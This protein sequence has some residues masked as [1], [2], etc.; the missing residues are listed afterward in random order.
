MMSTRSAP[1]LFLGLLLVLPALGSCSGESRAGD[2]LVFTA[3]PDDNATALSARFQPLAD[4][5]SA[6]LGVAVRYVPTS[7]YEASVEAFK[8]GDVQLAW[9]GGLTGAQARLAVP[10]SRAVA[11][12]K[13]DPHFKSYFIAHVDTGIEPS[14]AFPLELAQRS[15]TFG[16]SSSTSGRLMPEYYLRKYTGKS[17]TEFFGSAENFSGSHDKTAALVQ[18]GTFEAGALN[19][20]T[21]DRLVEDG[22]IDPDVARVVWTTPEYADYNWTAHP[23]LEER[24]GADFIDKLQGALVGLKDPELLK[25]VD[26]VEGLIPASNA[27]FEAIAELARELGFV[28]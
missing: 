25:A 12:G 15:F 9:F 10:G 23:V 13:V 28:R 24:F 14:D 1:H 6:E 18:A 22:T 7:S 11:Q 4:R 21:Y 16:A 27:D 3:I 17:P 2:S 19:F 26:R 5:L 20:K 8:N